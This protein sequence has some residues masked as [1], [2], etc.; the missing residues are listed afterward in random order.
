MCGYAYTFKN[1]SKRTS[2]ALELYISA[3]TSQG[4]PRN[5]IVN[6]IKFHTYIHTFF[7]LFFEKQTN[8]TKQLKRA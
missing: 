4:C 5:V 1:K 7:I 8:E 2:L 6:H 3:E